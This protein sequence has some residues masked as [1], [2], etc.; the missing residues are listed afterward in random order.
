M[1]AAAATADTDV[2]AAI[3]EETEEE[4]VGTLQGQL[5]P[6][7]PPTP[8]CASWSL[9]RTGSRRPT[10]RPGPGT[11]ADP[12]PSPSAATAVGLPMAA[13][14]IDGDYTGIGWLMDGSGRAAPPPVPA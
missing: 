11:A 13:T 12:P 6:L 8:S 5:S 9:P 3:E 7:S 14:T 1:E 10:A 2:A 4:V